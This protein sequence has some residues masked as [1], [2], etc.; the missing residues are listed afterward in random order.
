MKE[1]IAIFDITRTENKF[2]LFDRDYNVVLRTT[3]PKE[4]AIDDDGDPCEDIEELSEWVKKTFY[5]VLKD[6]DYEV[7]AVNFSTYGASLVH[8]NKQGKVVGP[9]YDYNKPYPTELIDE[10]INSYGDRTTFELSV[11]SRIYGMQNAGLQLYWI[12]KKKP[13]LF[14]QINNSL[15]LPQYCSYLF[16]GKVFNEI[17]SLGC[18][19]TLWDYQKDRS[20]DWIF[21]EKFIK[22]FP[23]LIKTTSNEK[24][25]VKGKNINCGIGIHNSSSSLVPYLMSF[26]KSFV[27]I[28]TDLWAVTFNLFNNSKLMDEG[29]RRD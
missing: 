7:K 4:N 21:S 22:F 19:S 26:E 27:L 23:P 13:E 6:K 12:K 16:S 10:F 28:N 8:L 17:S 2:F 24:I 18:H 5:E 15:H 20:H 9:L 1:V 29:L 3:A 14:K 11:G 25:R